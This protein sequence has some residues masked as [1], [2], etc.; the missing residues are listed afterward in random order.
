MHELLVASKK[1][2]LDIFYSLVGEK[3]KISELT[4]LFNL[5]KRTVLNY[6]VG[7]NDDIKKYYQ[8]ESIIT[9][10]ENDEYFI[11]EKLWEDRFSYYYKIKLQY[12]KE[13]LDFKVLLMVLT[14]GVVD[15]NTIYKK[16]FI[17]DSY[18]CRILGRINK[19]LIRFEL[20]IKSNNN[21]LFCDGAEHN[22]RTYTYLFLL[23]TFQDIEW[24]FSQYNEEEIEEKLSEEAKRICDRASSYKRRQLLLSF[25]SIYVRLEHGIY[26]KEPEENELKFLKLLKKSYDISSLFVIEKELNIDPAIYNNEVYFFNLFARWLMPSFFKDQQ[27]IKLGQ[28]FSDEDHPSIEFSKFIIKELRK[29]LSPDINSDYSYLIKYY[30]TI[31]HFIYDL[32]GEPFYYLFGIMSPSSNFHNSSENETYL[33]IIKIVL[34]YQSTYLEGALRDNRHFTIFFTNFILRLIKLEEHP[35]IV[36]YFH[37]ATSA[38]AETYLKQKLR[39]IFNENI[40]AFTDNYNESDIVVSDVLES[41]DTSKRLCLFDSLD[42]LKEWYML[43][44][45]IRDEYVNKRKII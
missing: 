13:S 15:I 7:L 4:S 18:L 27:R 26:M 28:I 11:K 40:L 43:L 16:L 41:K 34:S 5:P 38:I 39:S 32:T 37:I 36:V 21:Q 17:S 30:L 24:P 35:K 3:H 10:N 29:E 8:I 9:R 20:K 1:N 23:E 6:I 31:F 25:A 2:K 44:D 22:V 12:L 42:N 33:K 14:E 19:V 45:L